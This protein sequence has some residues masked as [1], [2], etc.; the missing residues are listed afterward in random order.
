MIPPGEGFWVACE[1]V[2]DRKYD[3]N[4][5]QGASW[6]GKWMNN[7]KVLVLSFFDDRKNTWTEIYSN[8]W[9]AALDW[10][11]ELSDVVQV[12]APQQVLSDKKPKATWIWKPININKPLR[13][14]RLWRHRVAQLPQQYAFVSKLQHAERQSV[15][16]VETL[17]ISLQSF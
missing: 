10:T 14:W 13:T 3:Q 9:K 4:K 11:M 15:W 7:G 12:Q 16:I 2:Y 1:V 8:H 17:S 6:G 5:K